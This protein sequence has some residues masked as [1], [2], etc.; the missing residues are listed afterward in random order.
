MNGARRALIGSLFE[1]RLIGFHTR[2][3][4]SGFA[5][6]VFFYPDIELQL[7]RTICVFP[8]RFPLGNATK[9]FCKRKDQDKHVVS[10][11]F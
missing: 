8:Y 3:T 11:Y 5:N 1:N 6:N 4:N 7:L 10:S 2:C 9:L